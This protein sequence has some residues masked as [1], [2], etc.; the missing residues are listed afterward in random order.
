MNRHNLGLHL[1]AL[2]LLFVVPILGG[3][4]LFD[5]Q[6][7][8]RLQEGV[9]AADLSL[10]EAIVLEEDAPLPITGSLSWGRLRPGIV[11]HPA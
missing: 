2:Y 9:A 5:V 8:R 4:I 10:V 6:A 7:G 3:A 11:Q 1:L